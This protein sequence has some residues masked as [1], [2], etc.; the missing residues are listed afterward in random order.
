M[1][2]R[3]LL[4]PLHAGAD[5]RRSGVEQRHA[6]LRRD[7]PQPVPAA[8]VWRPLVH[9]LGGSVG[10]RAVGDV[11]V[12]GHPAHVGGAPVDVGLGLEVEDR[13]VRPGG[14]G[15]VAARGVQDA[16]GPAG[17]AG[18]V[19][20]E[21]RL[22]GGEGLRLMGVGLGVDDVGPPD[23]AALG[24]VDVLPGALDHDD[25]RDVGAAGQG[26]VEDRLE[27]AR[28]AAAV[29]AVRGDH[30]LGLRVGD[31]VD[32]RLGGEAAEH[33]RVRRAEAGAGQHRDHGLGDH[34]QVDADPVAGLDA[35]R[36]QGVRGPAHLALQVGVRQ[37][38]TV[39]LGLADPVDRDPLA[40][41][42]GHVPVDAVDGDVEGAVGE[43]LGERRLPV[44]DPGEGGLP[45][46]P[47]GLLG[48]EAEPVGRG[49]LVGL[50][51][52]VGAGGQ[53]GR[54]LEAAVLAGQGLQP[55][56]GVGHVCSS[57]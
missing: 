2:G 37:V 39:A 49:P 23:V 10:Q 53:L 43:P 54:R 44:E 4:A 19:E 30:D 5:E 13:P 11:A 24:P 29:A 27:A 21:Q 57:W 45:L 7:L 12:P 26:L 32:E 14:L 15:E 6:V 38:T 52:D 51:G 46:Q 36:G 1:R 8:G 17:G 34:R 18:G 25:A 50:S 35:E 33:H 9:H 22:L 40:V 48:P 56:L 28:G 47:A 42:G 20:Q 16:L 31:P 41:A 55:G 3:E